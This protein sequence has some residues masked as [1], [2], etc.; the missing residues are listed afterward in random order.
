MKNLIILITTIGLFS[1]SVFADCIKAYNYRIGVEAGI[2]AASLASVILAPVAG[3]QVY[4]THQNRKMKELIQEAKGRRVGKRTKGLMKSLKNLMTSKQIHKKVLA[5]NKIGKLCKKRP[6]PA[7]WETV[8]YAQF[9]NSLRF[10]IDQNRVKKKLPPIWND[11][12]DFIG[13]FEKMYEK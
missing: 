12:D 6:K 11:Y 3:T 13:K 9:K 5:N 1:S 4:V 7:M 10:E 2:G 8:Y